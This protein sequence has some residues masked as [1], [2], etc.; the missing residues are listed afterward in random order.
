MSQSRQTCLTNHSSKNER[1]VLSASIIRRQGVEKTPKKPSQHL[2]PISIILC[3]S[4]AKETRHVVPPCL[5]HAS[6]HV[7]SGKLSSRKKGLVIT[8]FPVDK[9]EGVSSTDEGIAY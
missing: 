5:L 3:K 7:L 9:R 1:P 4:R 6:V 8:S 2:Q